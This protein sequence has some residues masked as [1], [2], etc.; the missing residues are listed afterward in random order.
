MK[1]DDELGAQLG[2]SIDARV[3]RLR[4]DQDLDDL[5]ARS[6]QRRRRQQRRFAIGGTVALIAVAIGAF[7][8]GGAT[9]DDGGETTAVVIPKSSE[10]ADLY[11]PADLTQAGVE[12]ATRAPRRLRPCE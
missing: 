5:L 8:V 12:I 4:P 6:E 11:A 9:S 7:V 2:R 1:S 3:R 10:V